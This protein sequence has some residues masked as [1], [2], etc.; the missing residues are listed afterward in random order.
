MSRLSGPE[1]NS[2]LAAIRIALLQN[3][4]EIEAANQLDLQRAR[5]V[6]LAQPL[7]KRLQFQRPQV[8]DVCRGL[9]QLIQLPDPVNTVLEARELD[10]GLELYRI[11]C[12]LG[13]VGVVFESRPD[14]LVQIAGLCL[15]SGNAVLLK[16]GS[17]AEHTNRILADTILKAT[18]YPTRTTSAD[19]VALPPGWLGLLESR[20]EVSQMLSLDGQIDLLI[21]RGSQDFVRHIMQHTRIPVMGHADGVCHV[22]IDQDCDEEMALAI[23]EDS[24]TQYPAACNAAETVLVHQKV[25]ASLLPRLHERLTTRHVRLKG[26]PQTRASIGC[27]AAEVADWSAEYLD[28]VLAVRVVS[29]IDDALE[30]I[31]R[32]GSRH[33]DVIVTRDPNTARMFLDQVDSANV[34]WNASSRFADGFRYGLGAEVGISTSKFH[35][36]GPVGL[37]GLLTYK[38]QLRGQG[39]LVGDYVGPNARSF[40]HRPLNSNDDKKP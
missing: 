5:D 36:R 32:Y 22:Y 20:E 9:D 38:W 11:S 6:N 4:A 15:K 27:E 33:T 13:V 25:A 19:S 10:L 39:H 35:A 31:L 26:C 24:K 12:P 28:L 29:S 23:T 17:E 37:Q 8:E 16:G 2:A 3:R 40:L 1:K 34:F 18:C 21:P 7:L 14:A 30:H